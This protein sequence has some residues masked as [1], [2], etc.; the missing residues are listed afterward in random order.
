MAD[1]TAQYLGATTRTRSR[2]L[3]QQCPVSQLIGNELDG[4]YFFDD[5]LN[6]PTM[7]PAS[8]L[9]LYASYIDTGDTIKGMAAE[10]TGVVELLTAAT[11]NNETWITTGGNTAPM[12][13]ISDVAGNAY[14]VPFWFEARLKVQNVANSQK[15]IY[16]GLASIARAAADTI[17]DGGVLGDFGFIGF[18]QAEAAGATVNAMYQKIGQALT[19]NQAAIATLVADTYV[20]LGF[21]YDP[22]APPA[23]RITWFLN[24]AEQST[25]V[26]STQAQAATFPG[27]VV[28]AMLLG[29]KNGAAAVHRVQM[30]WWAS[31]QLWAS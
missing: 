27:A 9:G 7:S 13:G 28:M 4:Y 12:T 10:R 15:N 24:N 25:Y 30:D 26:T 5:F 20:K 16:V 21:R 6:C 2:K 11:D 18:N 8:N 1:F 19:V 31:A 22:N 3:W 23:K 14:N 17:T 29:V